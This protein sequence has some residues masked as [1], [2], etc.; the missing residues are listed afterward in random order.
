MSLKT[1]INKKKS[2]NLGSSQS[3]AAAISSLQSNSLTTK[4]QM[5][6]QNSQN[7]QNTI[8]MQS[9]TQTQQ[10]LTQT[11]QF[12]ALKN[13]T[14]MIEE[15]NILG[16]IGYSQY[17]NKNLNSTQNTS[18]FNQLSQD[19]VNDSYNQLLNENNFIQN[20]NLSQSFI[21]QQI[22]Q[23]L[24]QH[25]LKQSQL[26]LPT[27]QESKVSQFD[28]KCSQI[29]SPSESRQ[30]NPSLIQSS[31]MIGQISQQQQLANYQ[32]QLLQDEIL[33]QKI[34]QR[35]RGS[36]IYLIQFQ[37][38]IKYF[39]FLILQLIKIRID[40]KARIVIRNE[41]IEKFLLK[42]SNQINR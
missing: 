28:G 18:F 42:Q 2:Q 33:K 30:N 8:Q 20:P 16:Q 9:N 10:I 39:L 14:L 27:I 5:A 1:Y 19:E 25:N 4:G 13:S 7:S 32:M 12:P 21:N 6:S 22:Y 40:P 34:E 31:L 38:V 36:Q 37:N 23:L 11:S 15:P 24:S 17:K 3:S 26:F 41:R 29:F 35:E